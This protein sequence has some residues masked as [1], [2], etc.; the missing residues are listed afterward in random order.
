M[1]AHPGLW[2]DG[3]RGS[4]ADVGVGIS[5]RHLFLHRHSLDQGINGSV[6]EYSPRILYIINKSEVTFPLRTPAEVHI[7]IANGGVCADDGK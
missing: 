2:R 4:R 3:G 6:D 5:Q 7:Q 1:S